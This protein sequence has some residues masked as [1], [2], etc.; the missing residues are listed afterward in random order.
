MIFWRCAV[1]CSDQNLNFRS[2]ICVNYLSTKM[3]P[4]EKKIELQSC[5]SRRDLQFS[6]KVYLHPSSYKLVMI[7]WKWAVQIKRHFTGWTGDNISIVPLSPVHPTVWPYR[8]LNWR[9]EVRS[10]NFFLRYIFLKN[11]KIN[12]TK[13]KN[14]L[15]LLFRFN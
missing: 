5:R 9:Q 10:T 7:F 4:N 3:A 1:Q 6:Y 13:I 14:L 12:N 15:I 11:Q 8:Q 2:E